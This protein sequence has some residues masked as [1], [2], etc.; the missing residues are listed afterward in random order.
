MVNNIF[1]VGNE[2]IEIDITDYV[3]D[4]IL[5]N[6]P[7]YGIGISFHPDIESFDNDCLHYIGFL[8]NIHIHFFHPC[9][10]TIYNDNIQDDRTNFYLN[11]D[12]KLYFYS[13]VGGGIGK[14]R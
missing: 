12:N 9:I 11:K 3:N 14:F 10:E 2:S 8:L 5:G 6:Q 4:L 7:N 13:Y 1:D